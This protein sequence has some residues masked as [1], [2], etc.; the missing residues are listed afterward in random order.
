MKKH[1]I[2][3]YENREGVTLEEYKNQ[4]MKD[5]YYKYKFVS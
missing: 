5:E 2:E 4:L 3:I 1:G